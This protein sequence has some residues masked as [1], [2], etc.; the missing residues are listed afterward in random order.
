MN[1]AFTMK[2]TSMA[3]NSPT[4]SID[5]KF[6]CDLEKRMWNNTHSKKSLSQIEDGMKFYD[7]MEN[8]IG[9][10]TCTTLVWHLFVF[11]LLL[12]RFVFSNPILR[13]ELLEEASFPYHQP[14]LLYIWGERDHIQDLFHNQRKIGDH[15]INNLSTSISSYKNK[16][17]IKN[18]FLENEWK[19]KNKHFL[20]KYMM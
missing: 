13:L 18:K 2:S 11:R 6:Y 1:I 5:S 9:W 16:S 17:A 12:P 20:K 15:C 3:A 7:W 14:P 19:I 10:N 8:Q 4:L